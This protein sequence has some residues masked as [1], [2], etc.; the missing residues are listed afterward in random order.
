MASQA[1]SPWKRQHQRMFSFQIGSRGLGRGL[2]GLPVPFQL[3]MN[4]CNSLR[5]SLTSDLSALSAASAGIIRA[6]R[7]LSATNRLIGYRFHVKRRAEYVN[8]PQ[9]LTEALTRSARQLRAIQQIQCRIGVADCQLLASR[10]ECHHRYERARLIQQRQM[11]IPL[12][13]LFTAG[14]VPQLDDII[15]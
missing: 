13:Q 5:A 15:H 1:S 8:P 12:A 3:P 11:Q 7:K 2:S 9:V 14:A 4:S 6:T 10:S